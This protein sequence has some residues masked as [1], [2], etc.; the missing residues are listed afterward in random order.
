MDEPR[1]AATGTS[2]E[3][4]DRFPVWNMQSATT[5]TAKEGDPA[6]LRWDN[7]NS[8]FNLQPRISKDSMERMRPTFQSDVTPCRLPVSSVPPLPE[9]PSS[10]TYE[11][12]SL[13][14][15]P[16]PPEELSWG[17]NR[18]RNEARVGDQ[19]V[20]VY[21]RFFRYLRWPGIHAQDH[22]YYSY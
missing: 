14:E 17:P 16:G 7:F 2:P 20:R 6:R 15:R 12:R 13:R 11:H 5:Q 22:E 10:S 9:L 3:A 8:A 1:P 21:L 4:S 19:V 18:S